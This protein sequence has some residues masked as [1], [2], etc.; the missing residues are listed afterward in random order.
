M[1]RCK[2]GRFVGTNGC[3]KCLNFVCQDCGK[4]A[5]HTEGGS[6]DNRCDDCWVE[7]DK[8]QRRKARTKPVIT[9]F[10]AHSELLRIEEKVKR[11]LARAIST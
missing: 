4:L 11:V 8:K 5:D 1:K 10:F 2:C 3:G 9:L 6:E 7:N